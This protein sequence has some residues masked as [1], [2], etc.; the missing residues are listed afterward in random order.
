MYTTIVV[1]CVAIRTDLARRSRRPQRLYKRHELRR[2]GI[3]VLRTIRTS[4]RVLFKSTADI[5]TEENNEIGHFVHIYMNRRTD[6]S[7]E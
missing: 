5:A 3:N 1:Y 7:Y 2:D 6:E 4:T